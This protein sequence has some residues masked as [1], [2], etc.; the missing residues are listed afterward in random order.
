MKWAFDREIPTQ[1]LSLMCNNFEYCSKMTSNTLIYRKYDEC[2]G[3][4]KLL[5]WIAVPNQIRYFQKQIL[6]SSKKY[7][8]MYV[9]GL[10]DIYTL[11]YAI[12]KYQS[13]IWYFNWSDIKH[14]CY[15]LISIQSMTNINSY[16][17]TLSLYFVTTKIILPE[18]LVFYDHS[19]YWADWRN[20]GSLFN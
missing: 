14:S 10:T 4:Q 15:W 19:I 7:R 16:Y 9:C 12:T 5:T 8:F 13:L 6:F 3:A 20:S 1:E 2:L 17:T 18:V 11:K